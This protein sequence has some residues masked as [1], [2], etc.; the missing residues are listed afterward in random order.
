[1]NDIN[2]KEMFPIQQSYS[3]EEQIKRYW[4]CNYTTVESQLAYWIL[5]P[6]DVKPVQIEKQPIEGLDI[7]N[8]GQYVS[9]DKTC[10]LLEVSV[11]YEHCWYEMNSA[12]WLAKKLNLMGESILHYRKINGTSTG[13]YADILTE[14]TI[15]KDESVI[16]RFTVLKDYDPD[17]SGANY[18]MVKASCFKEDYQERMFD[19]LQITNNWDLINK[20]NW[21]MAEN[22]QPFSFKFKQNN[23]IFYFPVS[24]KMFKDSNHNNL[25]TQP[26]RFLLKHEDEGKNI[27]I[28]NIYLYTKTSKEN[29]ESIASNIE[30]RF[31]NI[32]EFECKIQKKIVDNILNPKLEKVWYIQG[33]LEYPE[34]KFRAFLMSYLIQCNSGICYIES[35]GPRPNLNNYYWEAGKRCIEFIVES[36]D[37]MEF[38]KK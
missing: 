13:T 4:K 7:N 23:F 11:Y 35:I 30:T 24:W 19:M 3:K 21:N 2:N 37:N 33:N 32:S 1:M 25:S 22:L 20:T 6:K 5:L 27:G 18:F 12:D 14:K 29:F 17:F 9:I 16:S 38:A 10:P 36:F 28:V 31:K 26:I 15:N 8:I 34:K